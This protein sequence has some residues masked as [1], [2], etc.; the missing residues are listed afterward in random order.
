MIPTA[1]LDTNVLVQAVI[2]SPP[3]AS[4][5][6]LDA[7][8]EHKFRLVYSSASLDE[9]LDVLL[10]PTIRRRHGFSDEEVV[11][12]IGSLLVRASCYTPED[13]ISAGVTRDATDTHLLALA[14]ESGADYLVTNDHRHLLRL[15]RYHRTE[16][17]TPAVFLRRLS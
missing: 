1:I 12:F 17:V 7:Y 13:S 6:V 2:S 16:I 11:D 8:Y 9:L 3:A 15:R 5:R 14:A 10:L 4:A